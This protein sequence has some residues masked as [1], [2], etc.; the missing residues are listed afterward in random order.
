[1]A[2]DTTLDRLNAIAHIVVVMME[3]RS[4]D[5]MLGYLSL[6][7]MPA[8]GGAVGQRMGEIHGLTGPEVNFNSAPDGRRI[9]IHAFNADAHDVQRMGE[10]LKKSLDPDHSPA[11]VAK[12]LGVEADGRYPMDGFVKAFVE[13]RHPADQ[14]GEDLWMVPMGYY[15]AKDLPAYD[16]LARQ[17]CVCDNWHSSIPGDTWPNRLYSLAGT[18]SE[19]AHEDFFERF[20]HLFSST[21]LGGAPIFDVAAFTHQLDDSQWRWYSH[22][23]ATLRAADA[24]Y[25]SPDDLKRAN[26]AYFDRKK[27]SVVTEATESLIVGHDS[28]LDDAAKGELREV[29]WID[30]NFIDLNILDPNSNDDHPPTDIRAGQA[31]ILEI[32][33]ALTRSPVWPDTMLVIVYDEHGGFYDHVSPPLIDDGSGYRSLGVR[34]PAIVVGPRVRQS[35][36]HETLDHTVLIKT[37]LKRFAKDPAQAIGRM[38]TRVANAADLGIVL[39]DQPRHNIPSHDDARSA[40]DQWRTQAVAQRR[41]AVDQARSPAPDGAGHDLVLQDFQEQFARFALP[42]RRVL[43]PGQP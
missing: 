25:R 8:V 2:G 42:M 4:F 22:D 30:P 32:Y 3:N 24:H 23:P 16:F 1:M 26:F 11:G 6:K 35:V 19:P 7:E 17:F 18:T 9:P 34:V 40:I 10:A 14:V 12:Q 31:F 37:I 5:H 28:F 29:S 33:D 39:E 20:K 36:C 43:P 38:G 27:M 13:S 21:P 41:A 15:T